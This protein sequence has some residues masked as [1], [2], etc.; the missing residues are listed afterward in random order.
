MNNLLYF[1][2]KMAIKIAESALKRRVGRSGN[3]GMFF[4]GSIYRIDR[5]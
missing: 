1:F 2:F 4:L 5:L 3:T